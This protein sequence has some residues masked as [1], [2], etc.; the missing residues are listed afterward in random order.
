MDAVM[1]FLIFH[2]QLFLVLFVTTAI[3]AHLIQMQK[4]IRVLYVLINV[5]FYVS[6]QRWS[7]I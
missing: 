6:L 2:T 5:I 3:A 1:V 7:Y 4:V